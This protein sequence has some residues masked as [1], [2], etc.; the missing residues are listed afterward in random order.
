MG[1]D[2]LDAGDRVQLA[3]ARVQEELSVRERLEPAT[4]ARFRPADALGDRPDPAPVGGVQMEDPVGLRVTDRAQHD[5]PGLV[6]AA[7]AAQSSLATGG[8]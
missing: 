5:G 4:D 2:E 3:A 7:H 1:A 6:R 8:D